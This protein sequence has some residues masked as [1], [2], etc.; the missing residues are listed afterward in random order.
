M[1]LPFLMEFLMKRLI[2]IGLILLFFICSKVQAAPLLTG[3]VSFDDLTNLYTYTYQLDTSQLSGQTIEVGI[4]QNLGFDFT[5]PTPTSFT[6]PDSDWGFGISVGGLRNSGAQNIEGSFWMWVTTSFVPSSTNGLLQFSFTTERGVN[7]TL[8]NNYFIFSSGGTTGPAE[9][10]GFIEV[11][12]IVGPEFVNI[13][14]V[15]VTAVPENET[16]MMMVAGLAV[17][18]L[19]AKHQKGRD[20]GRQTKIA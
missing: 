15:P 16:Y 8:A 12:H 5:E 9:N 6:K 2:N 4:L 20:K 14:E 18:G 17:I 1:L 13:N 7:T 3:D 11:G 19:I 10:S